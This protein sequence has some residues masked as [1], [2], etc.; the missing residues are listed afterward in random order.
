MKVITG[1]RQSGKTHK[2]IELANEHDAYLAVHSKERA[3]QVYHNPDYPDCDRFPITYREL[4][5][6]PKGHIPIVIDDVDMFV[7]SHISGDIIG[8]TVTDSER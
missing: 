3:S 8:I 2:A 7:N 6:Y 4:R 5:E 1:P